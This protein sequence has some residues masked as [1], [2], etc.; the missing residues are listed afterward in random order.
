VDPR[1]ITGRADSA[2]MRANTRS[3][4]TELNCCCIHH[5]AAAHGY[6]RR[7]PRND[8]NRRVATAIRLPE[9]T[10]ARLQEHAE[11]R[12]VSVN[13]LVTRAVEQ[14]LDGLPSREQVEA[15]LRA[16]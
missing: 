3:A 12:D 4:R 8:T 13:W 16:S 7:M 9:T 10:H 2:L 11:M 14:F 15:T 6:V 1:A 5:L